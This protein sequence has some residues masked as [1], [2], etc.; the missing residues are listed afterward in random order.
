M[1]SAYKIAHSTESALI[2]VQNDILLQL[3]KQRGVILILLDLSAAFDTIDHQILFDRLATRLGITGTALAWFQSYLSQRSSAVFINNTSSSHSSFTCG[4]PQGSVLGPI[5][6]TLYTS[7]LAD[8]IKSHGLEYHFYADDS[9]VY[10]SFNA[11][12]E[13]DLYEIIPKVENCALAIKHWMTLNMLKLNDDKTEVLFIT[14]PYFQKSLPNMSIK[15]DQTDIKPSSCA[16]NIGVIFNQ[17]SDMTDHI[18]SVCRGSFFQLRTLGSI[19]RYL[20]PESCATLVHS[21]ITAKLDYCNSLLAGVPDCQIKRLQR[22]QNTAARI[23]SRRPRREHISPILASLHWLPIRQRIK[24]K[25]LVFV[26]KALHGTAPSYLCDLIHLHHPARQL[27]SS[28][29]VTLSVTKVKTKYGARAF[30]VYGPTLW[31]S[32][33]SGIAQSGSLDVFKYQLKTYLFREAFE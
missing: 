18:T 4:V 1:Q 33:P 26:F 9:Q 19:R 6:F 7:P 29:L 8:I 23:V 22:I 28:V 3:D 11:K 2:K 30:S 17:C 13:S 14:S 24:Y 31:N 5:I 21:F 25:I 10:I 12:S 20:T 16:R 15:I 32:L 27:R